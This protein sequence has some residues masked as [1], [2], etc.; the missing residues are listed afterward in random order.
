[1][2]RCGT[3]KNKRHCRVG[4]EAFRLLLAGTALSLTAASAFA[5][6]AAPPMLSSREVMALATFGGILAA[7]VLSTLWFMRLRGRTEAENQRLAAEL[8]AERERISNL[9]ALNA[10]KNRRIIFWEGPDSEPEFLGALPDEAGAP[11]DDNAFLAFADW[12]SPGSTKQ[13]DTAIAALRSRA[14][15]F[16][17][18]AETQ[19]DLTAEQAAKQLRELSDE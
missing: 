14:K 15:A 4:R 1:M 19:R 2:G 5:A 16:E 8:E 12:L 11:E 6:E 18:L 7:T 9:K 10:E 17:M 13:L 3:H